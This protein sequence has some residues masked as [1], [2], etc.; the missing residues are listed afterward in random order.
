MVLWE[1]LG[2]REEG[3]IKTGIIKRA[4]HDIHDRMI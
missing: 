4:N 3:S 1:E 2:A